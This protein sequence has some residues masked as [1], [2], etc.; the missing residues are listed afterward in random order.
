MRCKGIRS[1][2]NVHMKCLLNFALI[3]GFTLIASTSFG[4][5]GL[6]AKYTD[7][8]SSPWIT[9]DGYPTKGV[10]ISGYYW[11][12]LKEKRIEFLPEIGYSFISE[13]NDNGNILDLDYAFAAFNVDI[14]LFDLLNDCDCPTFSKQGNIFQRS[15]FIELSPGLDYQWLESIIPAADR[16]Y[17]DNSL[18]FRFGFGVGFDIGISDLVTI[19]PLVKYNYRT[20]PEWDPRFFNLGETAPDGSEWLFTA[21]IRAIFR[22]DYTRRYR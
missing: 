3:A 16:N 14:Y 18:S 17:S 13:Q 21:G 6:G 11:F 20:R 10:E 4:Q 19:T 7:L 9:P 22:P 2:E 1:I 15:F 5:F 12:R 8:T